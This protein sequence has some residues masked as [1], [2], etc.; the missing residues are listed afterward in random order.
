MATCPKHDDLVYDVGMHQ[1]EDTAYYLR[2]GFRVVGFEAEPDL[3]DQCR[4]LFRESLDEGRLTIIEGAIVDS[5]GRSPGETVRF[6]RNPGV[7][8][9]G[10]VREDWA[11]RNEAAGAPSEV[12]E[13]PAVDFSGCLSRHGMP[14]YMKIDIEGADLVCLQALRHFEPRPDYVSIEAEKVSFDRLVAEIELLQGLGYTAFQAVQQGGIVPRREPDE[15]ECVGHRF[16]VDSSGPFGR[17]LPGAWCS[18]A[19]LIERYRRI[20]WLY[21]L[22]GHSGVLRRL[23]ISRLLRRVLR[24]P[25]PGWY[26]THARHRSASPAR[27]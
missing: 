15:G 3:V 22:F 10:T 1:G 12:I 8:V 17:D 23:G 27:R 24:R 6:Y 26:D 5:A 2:K 7:S 20:F 21:R 9:W 19:Q 14:Y 13:V 16:T 18:G 11:Q 4:R 25:V